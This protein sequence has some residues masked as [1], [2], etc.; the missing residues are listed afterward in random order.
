MT[1]WHKSPID[2]TAFRFLDDGRKE[3]RFPEIK[4]S[5][6]KV[7]FPEFTITQLVGGTAP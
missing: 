1:Q 3:V 6:G 2:D 7:V 4:T 5:R